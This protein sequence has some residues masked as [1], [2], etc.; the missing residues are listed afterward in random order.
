MKKD[1]KRSK[2]QQKARVRSLVSKMHVLIA[3]VAIIECLILISFTT[4]SW[5]ETASSLIIKTGHKHYE[6]TVDTR[7]PI[8]NAY[9]FK[10]NVNNAT[11]NMSDV[12]DLNKYFSYSGESSTQNLYRFTRASSA[13]GKT[14]YFPKK[15]NLNS[16]A[17]TYRL[18]DIIDSNANYAHFD[19][20]VSNTGAAS[21]HKL[22]FYFDEANVFSV[23]NDTANLTDAQ[24][25]NIK[26]A[27]RISFQ[28]GSGTP[29]IYSQT[30]QTYGAVNTAA[31]GT[32]NITTTAIAASENQKLFTVGKNSEQNVSVRIWLEEKA[33]GISALTGEQLSGV[34][35]NINLKI[36]Y[37]ENDYD[38]LYFDDYTFSSGIL[39]KNNIG[40]HLTEDYAE[41]NNYR[42]FF[43]YSTNGSSYKYFPMTIDSNN[44]DAGSR[45]WV[46]CDN[47]GNASS[48]V[49]EITSYMYITALTSSGNAALTYSYFGYGV[50]D[51]T[52]FN[53]S[54]HTSS[55]PSSTLY[56]WYLKSTEPADTNGE[57]RF[58][59]YSVTN[60]ASSAANA[61]GVG[62]WSYN[63]P[64][65][66]VYFRDL[67]TGVTS[68]AYNAG[69]NFKYITNAVNAASDTGTGNRSN[70]MYANSAADTNANRTVTLYFDK[71]MDDGGGL[72]KSWVPTDW[73]SNQYIKFM[74][75][76]GGY[77]SSIAVTWDNSTN[78]VKATKPASAS[79]YIYTALGYSSNV[80]ITGGSN[81]TGV[82]CWNEIEEQPVY[83]S[84]ELIDNDVTSAYRYKIG[85]NING[86]GVKYYSLIPDETNMKFYAYVPVPG[87]NADQQPDYAAGD[88]LFQ[89][90]TDHTTNAS[91]NAYWYGKMR[92]GSRT[93]YPVKFD[94]D[95]AT[96]AAPKGYWNI[97]V[98]VDGTYEHFFWDYGDI[99]ISTDDQVLGTFSYNTV[100]HTG[101]PTYYD[102]T[103]NMIDEYRWYIPL[104]TDTAAVMP[105]YVFYKW[106]PY[107]GTVFTYSQKLSDGIYCVITEAGDTT[108]TNAFD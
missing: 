70:V 28:T 19:F 13:D 8:A 53:N 105:E 51:E 65:S 55:A 3:V 21:G 73:I 29:K 18:G 34:N 32:K 72:F 6:D 66:M 35:I 87:T 30:A 50:L 85:V 100:G 97:S 31:G 46:T 4:Y 38:F 75:C 76:P 17:T 104:D 82:G 22:K 58:S 101:T 86:N 40:G 33:S 47:D 77:Y 37:A 36:T 81:S 69:S 68:T 39:N 95:A 79:D 91:V 90:Y 62:G 96:S 60:T 94:T 84:T 25:T 27:M 43:A 26:N 93:Y 41:S 59:G 98:I 45:S 63:T 61:K 80:V 2:K 44:P 15:N 52:T 11:P 5:I 23:T 10:F 108:P 54:N 89:S 71:S 103:P 83:F 1:S 78:S 12:A 7:I 107:T 16:S 9:N 64:L 92:N 102:I 106:E 42:M 88:I 20:V 14:F 24:L 49:P 57:L 67:A 74:Y 99:S 48:T 56:K